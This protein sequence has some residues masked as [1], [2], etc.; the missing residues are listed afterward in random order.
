MF[1]DNKLKQK[2]QQRLT[3]IASENDAYSFFNLLTCE[4]LFSKL[5][6]LLPGH[7]ERLFPPTETLSM[8][9]A[10]ALST[11]SSCQKIVNDSAVKRLIGGLPVC[12]TATG[13]YCWARQRLPLSMISSLTCYLGQLMNEQV[14]QDWRWQGRPVRLIDGTTVSMPDTLANQADY[15][16]QGGQKP[17]LRFP[18]CRVVGVICLSS[19]AI[20]NAAVGRFNWER[21]E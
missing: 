18:I 8:F 5:E 3:N 2:K 20:L 15:P 10:Q 9:L 11:D 21:G 19:G 1:I 7:R 16:Q 6:A 12:S 4:Q 14:P 13:G 17:G